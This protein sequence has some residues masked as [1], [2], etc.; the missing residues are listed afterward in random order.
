MFD[1]AALDVATEANAGVPMEVVNPK[2]NQVVVDADNKPVTIT[3]RGRNS[4][5]LIEHETAV[6][7]RRLDASRRGQIKMSAEEIDAEAVELLVVCTV[8]WSFTEMAGEPYVCTPANARKLWSDPRFATIRVQ[9]E[10][11]IADDANFLTA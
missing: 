5:A 2:T 3:L 11:F 9:A 7:N 1:I 4:D 8:D 10:R 6:R